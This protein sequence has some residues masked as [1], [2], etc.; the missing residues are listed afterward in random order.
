MK[1]RRKQVGFIKHIHQTSLITSI[2]KSMGLDTLR[3][4][5]AS[6][7]KTEELIQRFHQVTK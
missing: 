1:M 6:Y 5:N 7:A 2:T 4:S 3:H